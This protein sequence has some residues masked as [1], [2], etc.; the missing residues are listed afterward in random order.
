M[1]IR[2]EI[3]ATIND[4]YKYMNTSIP[5]G[6]NGSV[7]THFL[8]TN[9]DRM[10]QLQQQYPEI[11]SRVVETEALHQFFDK[12]DEDIRKQLQKYY[13]ERVEIIKNN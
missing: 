7:F 6:A 5:R 1:S 2:S 12:S 4:W 10:Y 13:G 9:R 11:D 3:R 8:Y